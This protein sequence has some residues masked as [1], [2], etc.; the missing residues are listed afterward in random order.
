V[1]VWVTGSNGMLA[2]A[3]KLK[4]TDRKVE[5]VGTDR[6]LDIGCA[7][8]VQEFAR[9]SNFTHIINCAAYTDVD[10]A[11]NDSSA[12]YQTNT[13]GPS[14]LALAAAII[15]ANL[16]HFSTEYVF[17]GVTCYSSREGDECNPLNVY[18]MSKHSGEILVSS[19]MGNTSKSCYVIR[20]SGLFGLGG[21]NFVSTMLKLMAEKEVLRVVSDQV[22]RPTF[23]DDLAE[24]ALK[25]A[26]IPGEPVASGIYHF[27]NSLFSDGG[28]ISWYGFADQI[29]KVGKEAGLPLVTREIIPIPYAELGRLAPRPVHAVLNTRLFRE[30]TGE[31]PRELSEALREYIGQVVSQGEPVI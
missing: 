16:V 9:A 8:K 4:L 6:E 5:F 23:T 21:K 10:G 22:V 20:T 2:R 27:A 1:K 3:I 19:V 29:L 7:R 31:A 25:L 14:N 11:Q 30:T 12:A 26:G 17:S 24:A 15:E 13:F 28:G 18:G